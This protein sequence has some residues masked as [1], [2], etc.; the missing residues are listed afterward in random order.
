VIVPT[1]WLVLKCAESICSSGRVTMIQDTKSLQHI[2]R[3]GV[4]TRALG[5]PNSSN[6]Y[7][8]HTSE[9]V[10]WEKG[11][12]LIDATHAPHEADEF[13][14]VLDYPP[15]ERPSSA[16]EWLWRL[17]LALGIGAAVIWAATYTSLI[18]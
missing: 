11:W 6:P 14:K 9:H 2:Y 10:L 1:A 12:R 18:R 15:K 8:V 3:E 5:R 7:P 13:G 16:G 17:T 4:F